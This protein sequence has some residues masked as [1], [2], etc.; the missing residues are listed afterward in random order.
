MDEIDEMQFPER[1]RREAG[2][3]LIAYRDDDFS[4]T[5]DIELNRIKTIGDVIEWIYHL[6]EKEW[7][8]NVVIHDFMSIACSYIK[9][10]IYK[11]K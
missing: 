9:Y 1:V 2:W 10:D 5:Y 6:T 7:V 11:H 3:I 4:T 8:N